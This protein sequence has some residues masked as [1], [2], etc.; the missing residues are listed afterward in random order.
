MKK[1]VHTLLFIAILFPATAQESGIRFFHGNWDEAIALAKKEKKKIF[2]DFF[3]E[4][5]GPCLTMALKV[6]PLPQV[7]EVYNQHF[8]CVKIDA[9]KGEGRELARRYGVNSYPTYAF[10]D[11][12]NQ[13][14]LHRSGGNKPVAD[15]LADVNGA[16]N[17]KLS[18]VYLTEKYKSGKYDANFLKDYI[19]NKKVS[20]DR[21]VEKDFARLI[22][23]G[24]KLTDA[25]VWNLYRE[26]VGGYQN[27]YVKEVSDNY[28]QFVELFG[29]KAVDEKLSEV[30]TYAPMAFT[31][32]LCDFEGKDYNMQMAGLS[33]LFREEKYDEA[34]NAV[35]RLIADTTIDQG[36]F[37]KQLSFY[38]R[39][40]PGRMDS[41]PDF[42]QLVRKVGYMR[43]VAYNMVDRDDAGTH[44]NYAVALEYLLQRAQEEGKQIPAD[45]FRTPEYG[46]KGYDMRHPL[47]K[48]KPKVKSK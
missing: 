13:E 3:T 24:C 12:K 42:D 17:P 14:L 38:V 41:R 23:M 27:P 48:A 11:P 26:C 37:V 32:S 5:C 21:N 35:D 19:R 6:F 30:T 2:V 34:W 36:K 43:Y 45:L 40:N 10:I 44:Y 22:E 16:L 4:W 8:V 9:E 33:S 1:L 28:N 47:L 18:S 39:V 31:Q 7:G 29:K 25:D 20:G 15:F 46:K